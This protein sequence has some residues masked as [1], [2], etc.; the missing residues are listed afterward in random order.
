MIPNRHSFYSTRN[1]NNIHLSNTKH[2][3]FKN[4][5]FSSII[6]QWNNVDPHLRKSNSFLVFKND[7]LKF[8]R[9]SPYSV[10][11]CHNPREICLIT[12]LRLGINH[13]REHKFKHGFQDLLNPLCTCG[14]DVESTEHFLL[15]SPQLLMKDALSWIF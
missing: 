8:I 13:L 11:N 1:T 4:S 15:H 6:I 7:I 14:N 12:S 3:F 2:N 9:P 10:Y 5:L